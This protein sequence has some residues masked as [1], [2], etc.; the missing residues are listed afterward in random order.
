VTA[1]REPPDEGHELVAIEAFPGSLDG[2]YREKPI[3]SEADSHLIHPNSYSEIQIVRS[4]S[5]RWRATWDSHAWSGDSD[6]RRGGS[7]C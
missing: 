2:V 7:V 6:D 1:A 5:P 3:G 4:W